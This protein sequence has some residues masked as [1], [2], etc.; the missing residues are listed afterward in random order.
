MKVKLEIP[1]SDYQEILKSH[2]RVS[3]TIASKDD[4]HFEFKMWA[5][6]KNKT[7]HQFTEFKTKNA[8]TRIYKDQIVVKIEVERNAK[9][10]PDI[11]E[12]E[13]VNAAAL[14]EDFEDDED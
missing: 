3:G 2:S 13:G 12:N 7:G 1:D 14:V 11:I 10:A 9:N 4:T 6:R 8:K 5:R